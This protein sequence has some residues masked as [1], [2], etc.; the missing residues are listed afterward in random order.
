M[1]GEVA[2][3]VRE[4]SQ[5]EEGTSRVVERYIGEGR[6]EGTERE[7]ERSRERTGDIWRSTRKVV[8]K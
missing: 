5:G 7:R 2:G 8:R 6:I 1:G 4:V 3:I